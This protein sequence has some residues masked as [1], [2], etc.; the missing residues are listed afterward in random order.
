M[1][2]PDFDAVA[3]ARAAAEPGEEAEKRNERVFQSGV[4]QFPGWR[5]ESFAADFDAM[6]DEEESAAGEIQGAGNIASSPKGATVAELHSQIADGFSESFEGRIG[7]LGAQDGQTLG[8]VS[9][10]G[11]DPT[12][13]FTTEE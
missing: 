8:T 4:E 12:E 1:E 13:T 10:R 5:L 9:F 7:H 11:D 6:R 2:S 3:V